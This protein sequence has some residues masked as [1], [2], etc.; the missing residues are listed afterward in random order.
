VA[1]RREL[2]PER[3]RRK[4]VPWVAEGGEQKTAARRGQ[5]SSATVRSTRERPAAVKSIGLN[6][7]VPTPASL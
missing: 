6:M 5:T 7:S 1:A 2:A 3:D 4:R